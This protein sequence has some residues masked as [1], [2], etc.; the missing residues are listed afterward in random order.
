MWTPHIA[1]NMNFPAPLAVVAFLGAIAGLFLALVSA[2]IAW[3][4]RKPRF[5]LACLRV[6]FGGAA[7][8]FA[9]L[10]GFS[11]ASR[12]HVLALGQEKY[13]CEIDCH[14]AYSL[15]DVKTG[16]SAVGTHYLIAIRTRFDQT[17]ISPHRPMDV[18][19]TPSPRTVLLVDASGRQYLPIA[20][21][22]TPLLT[23][24]KPGKFYTTQLAFDIPSN[25]AAHNLRLLITSTPAWSDRLV[26]GDENSWLHHK[27]WFAL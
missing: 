14:L 13:F 3:F 17:T 9:L 2:G 11:L 1:S 21:E 10:L 23:P 15:L 20:V 25:V 6:V 12:T 18:P 5:A 26:I 7:I 16:P 8:Y 24:L 4:A 22:Q 19:L 27:T